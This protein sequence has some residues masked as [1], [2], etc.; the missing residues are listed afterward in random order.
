MNNQFGRDQREYIRFRESNSSDDW[1]KKGKPT[2]RLPGR[3][4][5]GE[6][7][8]HH[9]R[10]QDD[11]YR[12]N[13]DPTYEDEYGMRHPYEHGGQQNR[14]SDDLRSE[15]SHENHSGKGPKGYVRSEQRIK[16]EASEILTHDYDLDASEIEIEIKDRCLI[17]RGEVKNRR[18]KRLAEYLVEDISGIEDVDNQL[19]IKK[20]KV[21]GWI[22][23]IRTNVETGGQDGQAK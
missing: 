23:G 3:N 15:A 22:P 13:Y 12:E 5:N 11:Q 4:R 14:W 21:E 9:D 19:R 18:D 10:F 7:S 2:G 6:E 17:L 16:D 20:N 8:I 1:S